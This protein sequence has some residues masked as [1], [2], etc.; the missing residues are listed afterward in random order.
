ME[1]LPLQGLELSRYI[2]GYWRTLDWNK[3]PTELLSYLE[4]HL[5]MG[6]T[7][8][9]H[10]DI[11][12]DYQCEQAFGAAL[13]RKPAL[14]DDIEL[15]SKTGICLPGN[16]GYDLPHYNTSAGHIVKQVEQSLAN[17]GTDRLDLLLIHRPDPLMN[18]DEVAY[19]FEQLKQ[20]GKVLHFGVSNFSPSQ[21]ELLQSR[22]NVPLIT[23]QLEISPLQLNPLHDGTLDHLQMQNIAPM[24]WSCLGGGRLFSPEDPQARRI[25]AELQTIASEVNVNSIDQVLYAWVLALPSK[26]LPILGTGKIERIQSALGAFD[27]ELTREQW[28]RI[29]VAATGHNVP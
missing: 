24:A 2:A 16:K 27:I 18:A 11:Y 26:P 4:A 1:R 22:L 3:T 10:A 29:W 12:G 5:D 15:I 21:F 8:V 19:A 14:R 9:D 23:N 6:I 7:S 20:A 28:F 25:R 13:K 17:F